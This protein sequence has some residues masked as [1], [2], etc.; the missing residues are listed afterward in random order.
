MAQLSRFENQYHRGNDK[1]PSSEEKTQS[2]LRSKQ[3]G[4]D[5]ESVHDDRSNPIPLRAPGYGRSGHSTN[6]NAKR[7]RQDRKRPRSPRRV[8]NEI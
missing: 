5:G 8:N 2:E 3:C 4:K 7:R 1:E 6:P